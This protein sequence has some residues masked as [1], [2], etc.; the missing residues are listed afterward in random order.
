MKALEVNDGGSGSKVAEGF[1]PRQCFRGCR[2]WIM[3]KEM[4]AKGLESKKRVTGFWRYRASSVSEFLWLSK[5]SIFIGSGLG[6]KHVWFGSEFVW[7][8]LENFRSKLCEFLVSNSWFW[9]FSSNFILSSN[10]FGHGKKVCTCEKWSHVDLCMIQHYRSR[11]KTEFRSP[12]SCLGKI[13]YTRL[14]SD[15]IWVK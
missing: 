11:Y 9:R 12:C 6:F 13:Q 3:G 10:V 14:C 1:R 2:W 15:F 8:N 4:E 5:I 7:I